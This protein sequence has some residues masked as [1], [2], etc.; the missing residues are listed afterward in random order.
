MLWAGS[1]R[2]LFFERAKNTGRRSTSQHDLEQAKE[3]TAEVPQTWEPESWADRLYPPDVREEFPG[4][5]LSAPSAS[6]AQLERLLQ[7]GRRIF[8]LSAAPRG[9]GP[10]APPRHVTS[11]YSA[12]WLDG[13][14]RAAS[15]TEEQALR[16]SNEEGRVLRLSRTPRWMNCLQAKDRRS[17]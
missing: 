2:A 8:Q 4:H 11:S 9:T 6:S 10:P 12:G 13:Q 17:A 7:A 16:H 5:S 1:L 3:T 14:W 15:A